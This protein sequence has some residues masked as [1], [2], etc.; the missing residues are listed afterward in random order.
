[1]PMP[2]TDRGFAIS[3]YGGEKP[4]VAL[5]FLR[6]RL[7]QQFEIYEVKGGTMTTTVE[8]RDVPEATIED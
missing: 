3:S 7:Q 6:G 4:T 8:W 1:M 2:D 5:R